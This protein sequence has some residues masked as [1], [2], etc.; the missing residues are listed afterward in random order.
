MLWMP[1]S[2]AAIAKRLAEQDKPN[3]GWQRDLAASY[4]NVGDV[5]EAQGKLQDALDAYQQE[6]AIAKRLAEQDK[7]N[8]EWQRDLIVS[9]YKVG[10][11]AAKIGGDDNITQAKSL[12]Q[13]GLSLAELY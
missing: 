2:K 6:L 10:T 8:S 12:L 3:A 9:L 11:T 1:T 7:S 5:L 13:T 4:G